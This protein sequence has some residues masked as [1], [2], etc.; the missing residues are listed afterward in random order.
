MKFNNKSAVVIAALAM[1][2]TVAITNL[3]TNSTQAN[4]ATVATVKAGVT[5][6]L[7]TSKGVL[8]TNRALS[9]NTPW[10]VG[11]TAK[12]NGEIMY[13]VATNEYLRADD[14][15]LSGQQTQTTKPVQ[16]SNSLVATVG[17]TA[18]PMYFTATKGDPAKYQ[19][20]APNTSWKVRR[21]VTNG[22]DT[23]YE[24]STG[25]F[26]KSTDSTLNG[27]PK[28]VETYQG[29]EPYLGMK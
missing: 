5:A 16:T 29:F 1:A 18:A 26:I 24:V 21:V 14:S 28:N 25:D 19:T 3:T 9:P 17:N 4:A 2:T 7:V 23:Y 13:Q 20:L 10:A 6:R 8:I 11:K 22:V 12:I 15:T 27:T